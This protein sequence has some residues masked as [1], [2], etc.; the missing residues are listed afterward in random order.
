MKSRIGIVGG[1]Q[2]ARMMTI[3]AKQMGMTV[4]VLDPTPNAP[5]G[6]IADAQITASLHDA[7][8]M[9]KLGAVSDFITLDW[10]LADPDL[11]EMLVKKGIP[12]N[13]S[14]QTLRVIKDKFVQKTF[15]KSAGIPVADFVEVTTRDD[16]Q[17]A[18]KKFGY[19]LLLKAKEGGYD[20]KGNALI[21]KAVDISSALEKLN[22][23]KL[24]IEKFV[25]FEKELAIIVARNTNG[26]I[27][28]YPVVETI[29]KNN[30]LHTTIT[31]ARI[32]PL[33]TKK[34]HILAKKIMRHLKGA[35][36][37]GIELFLTA[38]HTILVNEIAPRVHN[39]GHATIEHT[40]TSQF[41]QHIR[42]VTGLPL[43][44]TTP[45]TP[46]AVMMNVL[47]KRTGPANITGLEKALAIS[48]ISVHFYGKSETKIERKM[49][50]L[51][52]IGKSIDEC[53][54][55]AKKARKYLSI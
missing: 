32:D 18:A 26:D 24:Y 20:G 23:T 11:L 55:K 40:M 51:T 29:H 42:A 37:F 49:G 50:H 41:E 36:V 39:S 47:G 38:T 54:K 43:G 14:P 2:L 13:P 46:A 16:I 44:E 21:K 25:P 9:K 52:V 33:L 27:K 5:A 3:S 30:I 12:V 10:E 6:Q 35:G 4:T 28:T 15:L 48:G 31:P 7:T 17:H 1:G 34:I 19:P 8:A 22:K 53:M 45:L